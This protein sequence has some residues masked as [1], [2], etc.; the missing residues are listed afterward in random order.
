MTMWRCP[1]CG[2]KSGGRMCPPC[3]EVAAALGFTVEE[4]L[5]MLGVLS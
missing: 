1:D 5:A 3:A 2:Q 4:R